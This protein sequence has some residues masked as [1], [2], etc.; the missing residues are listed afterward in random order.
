M[1][2]NNPEAGGG[3]I[4]TL[5]TLPYSPSLMNQRRVCYYRVSRQREVSDG[6]KEGAATASDRHACGVIS[7]ISWARWIMNDERCVYKG[8]C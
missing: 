1:K 5:K 8:V 2:N 4:Y 7:D 6:R 3:V